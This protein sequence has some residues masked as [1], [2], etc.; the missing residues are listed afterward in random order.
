M[1]IKVINK[2]ISVNSILFY[3][4][5]IYLISTMAYR[6]MPFSLNRI[7][8]AIMILFIGIECILK[9]KKITYIY[10]FLLIFYFLYTNLISIEKS[11]NLKDFIYFTNAIMILIHY[12]DKNNI[13]ELYDNFNKNKK[14]VGVIIFICIMLILIGIVSPSC[15]TNS[16]GEDKYFI[17]ITGDSHIYANSACLLLTFL[18]IYY[19]TKKR[20]FM[21]FPLSIIII[22]SILITGARTYIIPALAM[23]LFII[24]K[25][26]RERKHRCIIYI[27]GIIGFIMVFFYS[28][29]FIKFAFTLNNPYVDDIMISF[30]SGRSA[31]WKIDLIDFIN[32]DPIS[33]IIGR[34]FDYVYRL[35]KAKYNLHIWAHNDIINLLVTTG[36]LGFGI[37]IKMWIRVFNIIKFKTKFDWM[38]YTGYVFF[39][40]IFNGLYP[41]QHYLLSCIVLMTLLYVKNGGSDIEKNKYLSSI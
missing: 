26:I 12:T 37:Y 14:L 33:L 10:L 2:K 23:L 39:P 40:M 29:M 15:Y 31:F 1:I 32:Y 34:G 11:L 16:W 4:I 22:L 6:F 5:C 25:F 28:G 41:N 20:K 38:V 7:V 17:G 9:R 3:L 30:T 18:T 24:N 35:N 27:I 21:I 13:I 36:L 8:S 19:S